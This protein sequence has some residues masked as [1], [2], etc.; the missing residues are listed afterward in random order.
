MGF[1][2]SGLHVHSRSIQVS[3]KRIC[4]FIIKVSVVNEGWSTFKLNC[5]S[6]DNFLLFKKT[7]NRANLTKTLIFDNKTYLFGE[8]HT[9]YIQANP[10]TEFQANQTLDFIATSQSGESQTFYITHKFQP[11]QNDEVEVVSSTP[12]APTHPA[13]A[14]FKKSPCFLYLRQKYNEVQLKRKRDYEQLDS[15]FQHRRQEALGQ[16]NAHKQ[17]IAQLEQKLKDANQK[18]INLI[19]QINTLDDSHKRQRAEFARR[20]MQDDANTFNKLFR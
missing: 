20:D 15:D 8:S 11:P 1:N 13:M 9:F 14:E 16:L 12:A 2:L 5:K 18:R 6:G 3:D 17:I 7:P 4:G 19:Q 10:L